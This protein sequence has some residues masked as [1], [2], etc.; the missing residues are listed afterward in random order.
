MNGRF[1]NKSVSFLLQSEPSDSTSGR[2]K[3]FLTVC[4]LVR[5]LLLLHLVLVQY[6]QILNHKRDVWSVLPEPGPGPGRIYR[7]SSD[8]GFQEE[9][10][11]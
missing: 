11:N 10:T 5:L 7:T 1:Q 6:A 9:K 2:P 8:V 4:C 3:H